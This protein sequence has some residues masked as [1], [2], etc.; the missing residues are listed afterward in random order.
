MAKKKSALASLSRKVASR[1]KQSP[2]QNP[3]FWQGAAEIVVPGIAG[4]A[5]G[6][7]V[8]RIAYRLAR[9]KSPG[10]ARHAGALTPSLLAGGLFVAGDKIESLAPYHESATVGAAIAAAQALL[11][12]YLPQWGWILNDYHL[13]DVLPAKA[14]GT[15]KASGTKKAPAKKSAPVDDSADLEDDESWELPE[16][17]GGDALDDLLSN[18]DFADFYQGSLAGG[19][20]N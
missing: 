4:Y 10:L 13:D 16:S 2:K 17:E 7:I 9:K 6:R 3:A 8:G 1:K 18:D 5:A 11:Q 20:A 15:K 19:L 14:K 12:T